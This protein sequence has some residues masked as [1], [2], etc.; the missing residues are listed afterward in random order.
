MRLI[1]AIVLIA[2]SASATPA[3]AFGSC[4]T[5]GYLRS[6]D[7]RLPATLA[8][9]CRELLRVDVVT[10]R[11]RVPMRL[12][13]YG[14]TP[15]FD[16]GTLIAQVRQLAAKTGAA[17]DLLGDL[18]LS[19]VTI[20]LTD[21]PSP[22]VGAASMTHAWTEGVQDRGECKVTLFK[23]PRTVSDEEFLITVSHEIFHCVQAKTWTS[24]YQLYP[25]GSWW[26]EGSAEY[27]AHLV[28]PNTSLM[29]PRAR[30]FDAASPDTAL[31]DM[32]YEAS[33][34]FLWLHQTAGPRAGVKRLID[35]MASTGG[36]TEQASALRAALPL[37]RFVAF[38]QDY[39]DGQIRQPG[40]RR[41]PSSVRFP[42]TTVFTG[43]RT[44]SSSVQPFVIG[45]EMF[46]FR[47]GKSYDLK[48]LVSDG[49]RVRFQDLGSSS[50]GD[51]PTRVN[52]C[53]EDQ[54]FAIAFVS[55]D[56]RA[57]ADFKVTGADALDRRACCLIGD[58]Q[59]TAGSL[60]SFSR[61]GMSGGAGAVAGMGGAMTCSYASGD[62]LLSFGANGRGSVVWNNFKNV[63]TISAEG[64]SMR[65]TN[66]KNGGTA[67]EW[68]VVDNRAG[69][70]TWTDHDARWRNIMQIGPQVME[71][72][73]QEAPPSAR[74]SGFAYQ[75]TATTLSI[76]GIPGLNQYAKEH[77]RFGAPPR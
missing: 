40:G 11:L 16:E 65:H 50:W 5:G 70:W 31:I 15:S 26:I 14:A 34:F 6:F 67:F 58:W 69:K 36:R 61:A 59:P 53:S 18:D 63:C 2:L 30:D 13:A 22:D 38:A 9:E 1:L 29:D 27:F 33:I 64:Q 56:A 52:A 54:I 35:A 41:V 17:M 66:I 44:K 72:D 39:L 32:E 20:L 23:L 68:S 62:W 7:E 12:I 47:A 37:D 3:H 45:R 42:T 57:T 48:T 71:R 46:V 76:E 8:A 49:G 4:R 55:T 10:R 77:N 60:N 43:P 28:A 19:R 25:I 24:K 75:C 73:L 21:M 74:S 51:P